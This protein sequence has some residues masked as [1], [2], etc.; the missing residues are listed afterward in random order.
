MSVW[1]SVTYRDAAFQWVTRNIPVSYVNLPF[2]HD[3]L[4][5]TVEPFGD[6]PVPHG[7]QPGKIK[8]QLF[9]HPT[10][11]ADLS[12]GLG[13]KASVSFAKAL[14]GLPTPRFGVHGVYKFIAQIWPY[15]FVPSDRVGTE[16]AENL[17]Q[18]GLAGAGHSHGDFLH[19]LP[20]IRQC[21]QKYDA[22]ARD[23]IRSLLTLKQSF[24][25]QSNQQTQRQYD[26]LEKPL[27][28]EDASHLPF[29][30]GWKFLSF[31]GAL[32][33]V[34]PLKNNTYV[35][36][37]GDFERIEKFILGCAQT[38]MYSRLYGML[39]PGM[40]SQLSEAVIGW[41]DIAV[42]CMR[43]VTKDDAN[44]MAR[45]F[46]V[47]YFNKLA[48]FASDLSKLAH[49]TQAEKWRKEKLS[50]IVSLERLNH[51]VRYLPMKE[52][53]E[54]L[55]QYKMFP[56]A[57]YDYFGMLHRQH[58][59]YKE[60]RKVANEFWKSD[61]F[62]DIMR[63]YRWLL[64][65]GFH[66]K[67]GF[68]P[69]ILRDEVEDKNWHER[70]PNISPYD[71]PYGESPDIDFNGAFLYKNRRKDNLD[72]V[73][74]KA[75]CPDNIR[76][77]TDSIDLNKMDVRKKSQLVDVLTRDDFL[78]TD[79]LWK[80][81]SSLM[82]DVKADDKAES[83]KPNGRM[84]FELHTEAR[85][86][87]SEYEDSVAE[88]AKFIPGVTAGVSAGKNIEMMNKCTQMLPDEMVDQSLFI[89]FDLEKWSPTFQAEAHLKQDEI[90]AEA[91]G[92]PE[93]REA[94]KIFSEG[95]VHYV[96]GR[97][98]HTFDK[99]GNE[100]EGH[101]ARK[102][103]VYHCAVMGWTVHHL[104]KKGLLKK[105]V[106]FAALLDDGLVRC[107]IAKKGAREQVTAIIPEVERSYNLGGYFL[108][109]DKT[110]IS[111]R[112]AIYLNEIRMGGR[113]ITPG[114]KSI[115]KIANRAEEICPN[116][117]ADIDYA[118]QSTRGA[119]GAGATPVGAYCTYI[120]NVVDAIRRWTKVIDNKNPLFACRALLPPKI[121]GMG[122]SSLAMLGGAMAHDTLVESLGCLRAVG[123]RFPALRDGI[124]AIL[125]TDVATVKPTE[126]LMNPTSIRSL[127]RKLRSDR[128][129]IAIERHLTS[130]F[131]VPAIQ[132]IIARLDTH[133]RS[134]I[135]R[136]FKMRSRFPVEA[137]ERL[138]G[139]SVGYLF[140]QIV[141][142]FQK[143]KSAVAFVPARAL[144][145]ATLANHTE[146]RAYGLLYG[147]A[148][149]KILEN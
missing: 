64:I 59:M 91:F 124:N 2:V 54:V 25:K 51:L 93:L 86:C 78:D 147:K 29:L 35:I 141:A 135:G 71:I 7:L 94:H 15:V 33:L 104:R 28:L 40:R 44:F 6:F 132:P 129:N 95:K 43:D 113:S 8:P 34:D 63:Y 36:L 125:S 109:W 149:G 13:T 111:G 61:D 37:N 133:G 102:G 19:R 130:H 143:A 88:Y 27:P 56:T 68:C 38:R 23:V 100:Y 24:K 110:F 70:F 128:G 55:Q 83:K 10:L 117:V 131:R 139:S 82:L 20:E 115:L 69:G 50:R 9:A 101:F 136:Q 76:D 122:V 41:Q 60:R 72:L 103:T 148:G 66:Q 121:C 46:D 77:V 85:L 26:L 90:F 3:L 42:D 58:E 57:D 106:N 120:S 73:K 1:K 99:I 108:S 127:N 17:V 134:E 142:K 114:T 32:L 116:L 67:H 123:F 74:D 18:F 140:L 119:I 89:S 12:V 92:K 118:S 30:A 112:F 87:I 144:F 137:R 138:W 45:A 81:F 49:D 5:F 47:A 126:Q 11:V 79:E 22:P 75:I 97:I 146:A 52:Q 4:D 14:Q 98:H 31:R 84:F 16:L 21:F 105:G 48:S 65:V 107:T 62:A 80:R 96:K 145:R 53:F 39:N